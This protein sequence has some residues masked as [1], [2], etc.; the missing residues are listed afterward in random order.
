MNTVKFVIKVM[1]LLI[2]LITTRCS[3]LQRL[4]NGPE[5][6]QTMFEF[7]EYYKYV[8]YCSTYA[9]DDLT[10]QWNLATIYRSNTSGLQNL[11]R[12]SFYTQM[13]AANGLPEAVTQLCN[14]YKTGTG[15]VRHD[16]GRAFWWCAKAADQGDDDAKLFI[17]HQYKYGIGTSKN[18]VEALNIYKHFAEQGDEAS[19]YE[20]ATIYL[21]QKPQNLPYGFYWLK[22][23]YAQ[24]Y[25]DA[26][27]YVDSLSSENQD[28]DL[29][30]IYFDNENANYK[31][32]NQKCGKIK[33]QHLDAIKLMSS[34]TE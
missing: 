20:L 1:I 10:T 16:D 27:S 17:A 7:G 18:L 14:D 28:C 8:D 22:K 19:E 6:C 15:G 31:E 2:P 4:S 32:A 13:A 21:T 3:S 11:Q 30:S 24:K 29:H 9:D 25:D 33:H 5:D 23:A 26:V 34:L 12:S